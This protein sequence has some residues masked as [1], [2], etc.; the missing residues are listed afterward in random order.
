MR[1][2]VPQWRIRITALLILGTILIWI[3][4][5]HEPWSDEAQS[6]LLARDSTPS[7]LIFRV[8]RYEGTPPLWPLILQVPARNGLPYGSM[9]F[10]SIAIAWAGAWLF[11]MNPRV[12]TLLSIALPFSYFF[13]YQYSVV[14]RSYCLILPLLGLLTYYD[15]PFAS[16]PGRYYAVANVLAWVS[17]HAAVL[18]VAL[19]SERLWNW[20]RHERVPSRAGDRK[21]LALGVATILNFALIAV[22]VW[23]PSDVT[24]NDN[25]IWL[26]PVSIAARGSEMVLRAF[27]DLPGVGIVLF[28]WSLI[29]FYRHSTLFLFLLGC[30]ALAVF[31]GIKYF[32]VWHCGFVFCLWAYCLWIGFQRPLRETPPPLL[33]VGRAAVAVVLV[34]HIA[35]AAGS[36]AYDFANPYSGSDS[37]AKFIAGHRRPGDRVYGEGFRSVALQPYFKSN[38]FANYHGGAPP[39][40][41]IWSTKNDSSL[42]F[43]HSSD[44]LAEMIVI[45]VGPYEGAE[46]MADAYTRASAYAGFG[47][48]V[49]AA[50]RGHS[51][52][53]GKEFEE[54]SYLILQRD[55][56]GS[57]R[58]RELVQP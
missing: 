16:R 53:Y 41:W 27:H 43:H 40:Y 25:R 28:A 1:D 51:I 7:D 23:P 3:G 31:S 9:E 30:G 55:A 37:A 49:A 54:E 38:L 29:V 56:P 50:C 21:H 15:A 36:W 33:W 19:L 10:I 20:S 11:A 4:I 6:W 2:S 58:S 8:V 35:Y 14:A 39:A 47:F 26:N 22:V 42:V 48:R 12:P 32:N 52:W 5:R 46:N 17:A 44:P 57:H 24:F 18:S 13:A 34:S 45:N